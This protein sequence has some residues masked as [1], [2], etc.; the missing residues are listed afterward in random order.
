MCIRC[1]P[2]VDGPAI[3]ASPV[4]GRVVPVVCDLVFGRQSHPWRKCKIEGPTACRCWTCAPTSPPTVAVYIRG[5]KGGRKAHQLRSPTAPTPAMCTSGRKGD[6]GQW[7]TLTGS[8]RQCTESQRHVRQRWNSAACMATQMDT[9]RKG[10]TCGAGSLP[11]GS[12]SQVQRLLFSLNGAAPEILA[13]TQYAFP[14]R[15][16]SCA[17]VCVSEG[18]QGTAGTIILASR[19]PTPVLV[20]RHMVHRRH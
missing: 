18:K 13:F 17:R 5:G 10:A 11:S 12:A 15:S 19:F 9:R 20:P 6:A 16:T 3:T 2:W 14:G 8:F 7:R 1:I 4:V